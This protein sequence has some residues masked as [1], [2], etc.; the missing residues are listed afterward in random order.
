LIL[1]NKKEEEKIMNPYIIIE[2]KKIEISQENLD[3]IKNI[4]NPIDPIYPID[5]SQ[6]LKFMKEIN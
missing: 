3:I 1:I 6:E 5:V 4:I 2:G